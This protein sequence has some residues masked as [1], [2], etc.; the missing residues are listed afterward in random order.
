M[1]DDSGGVLDGELARRRA[2]LA[3][4]LR[5]EHLPQS[6]W[7]S[8]VDAVSHPPEVPFR[9]AIP[10]QPRS[11]FTFEGSGPSEYDLLGFTGPAL[12]DYRVEMTQSQHCRVNCSFTVPPG[13]S[14]VCLEFNGFG[15]RQLSTAE[16]LKQCFTT[17][18]IQAEIDAMVKLRIEQIKAKSKKRR[19]QRMAKI[20]E[21]DPYA[22][23]VDSV[24]LDAEL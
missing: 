1:R 14:V 8:Q 18:A 19:V 2:V 6:Q 10:V 7:D 22:V 20:L 12:H 21:K 23:M 17:Q 5:H 15:I 13:N 16:F 4:R 9:N 11:G 24:P 3:E